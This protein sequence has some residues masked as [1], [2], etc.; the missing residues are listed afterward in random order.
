MLPLVLCATYTILPNRRYS[1]PEKDIA[2]RGM[3]RRHP[4]HIHHRVDLQRHR[5]RHG[6]NPLEAEGEGEVEG[7]LSVEFVLE[8]VRQVMV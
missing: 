8:M 7:V 4:H 5:L 3:L 1:R 6:C 2:S